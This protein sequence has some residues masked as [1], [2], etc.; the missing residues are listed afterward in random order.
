MP[1][2]LE[3][4]I[5]KLWSPSKN[6]TYIGSTT[7]SLSRRLS[8]HLSNYKCYNNN[9]NTKKYCLTSY[10]V[11]ECDD[12]KIELLEAYPCNNRQQLEKKEGEYIKNNECCN[13]CVVGRTTKEYNEEHKE[14]YKEYNKQYREQ[15]KEYFKEHSKQYK[16]ANREKINEQQ[17]IRRLKK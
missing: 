5:Y 7:Q 14:K 16:E 1:N 15:N 6:I 11:L 3:G 2:Y 17:R 10:L 12:Y 13:K 4:K 9:D 8:K